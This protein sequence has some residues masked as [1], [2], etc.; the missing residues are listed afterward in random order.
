MLE[1]FIILILLFCSVA[2]LG[3]CVGVAGAP[4]LTTVFDRVVEF[5]N[6][7]FNVLWALS[8]VKRR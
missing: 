4:F 6:Q 5:R 8:P 1:M 7:I 2:P 3:P